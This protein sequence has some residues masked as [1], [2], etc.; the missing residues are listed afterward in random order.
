LAL[1]AFS[2]FICMKLWSTFKKT[3]P[4]K[5]LDPKD[6]KFLQSI[7]GY[8]LIPVFLSSLLKVG[9]WNNLTIES[10][11]LPIHLT[12][13]V[14]FI[15]FIIDKNHLNNIRKDDEK[16]KSQQADD[17]TYRLFH[18]IQ[19]LRKNCN[20]ITDALSKD[21]P[22][23]PEHGLKTRI[24]SNEGIISH[25]ESLTTLLSSVATYKVKSETIPVLD[26]RIESF[27][28]F[29]FDIKHGNYDLIEVMLGELNGFENNIFALSR[30]KLKLQER[31]KKDFSNRISSK[32]F[33]P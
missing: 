33:D 22:Q 17:L 27:R 10:E 5:P 31:L 8:L 11:F 6:K 18:N 1:I 16:N 23:L 7:F 2:T 3:K 15:V 14:A 25:L 29:T 4:K 21:N 13:W 24:H 32:S 9:S 26:S 30:S 19:T 12:I 20:R 28:I